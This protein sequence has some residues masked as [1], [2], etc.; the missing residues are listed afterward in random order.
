MKQ[1]QSRTQLRH[2]FKLHRRCM[3]RVL[4]ARHVQKMLPGTLFIGCALLKKC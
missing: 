1:Q 4:Q 3:H 2:E